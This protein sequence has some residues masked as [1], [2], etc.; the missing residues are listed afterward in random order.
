MRKST[1]IVGGFAVAALVAATGSAFTGTGLS[2]T[3]QA[4]AAQFVGGTVSQ[5]V[6]GATL[7]DISY[8][9]FAD[10]PA[11][12]QAQN[13][14]LTFDANAAGKTVSAV[15]NSGPNSVTATCGDVALATPYTSICTFV[16]TSVNNIAVTV[17]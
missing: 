5:D 1:K 4:S 7:S 14:T 8:G 15:L 11:D 13:V 9:D 17:A 16:A 3:G 2:T 10:A 12:T 6:T